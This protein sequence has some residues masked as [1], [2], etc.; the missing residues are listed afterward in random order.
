MPYL[1]LTELE[2]SAAKVMSMGTLKPHCDHECRMIQ[3]FTAS[4][5]EWTATAAWAKAR[6]EAWLKSDIAIKDGNV[7]FGRK[8]SDLTGKTL[9]D[10]MGQL[11]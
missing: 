7:M 3:P 2:D 4:A 6:W 11:R 10:T 1:S 8:A 9:A 5:D